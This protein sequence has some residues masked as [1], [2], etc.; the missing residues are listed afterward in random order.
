MGPAE[1]D[2]GVKYSSE[3]WDFLEARIRRHCPARRLQTDA[4]EEAA[5]P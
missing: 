3:V 4:P 1:T 5:E 2:A